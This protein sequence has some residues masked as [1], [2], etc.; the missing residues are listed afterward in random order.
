[1][2]LQLALSACRN[3]A[4]ECMIAIKTSMCCHLSTVPHEGDLHAF[5]N[6]PTHLHGSCEANSPR[7]DSMLRAR[8]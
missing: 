5:D 6:R 4:R 1:M 2:S 3:I 7:L 8:L